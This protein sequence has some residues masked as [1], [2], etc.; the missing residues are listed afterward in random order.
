MA[1]AI[2]SMCQAAILHWWT[3]DQQQA[4]YTNSLLNFANEQ[5]APLEASSQ[6]QKQ[7]SAASASQASNFWDISP[8]FSN[9]LSLEY[10]KSAL[11]ADYT[12]RGQA[13]ACE[14][15]GVTNRKRHSGSSATL[16]Q[17]KRVKSG[18]KKASASQEAELSSKLQKRLAAMLQLITPNE[19]VVSP[20][21]RKLFGGVFCWCVV[22][23][24]R[25]D[26]FCSS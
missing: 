7:A 18:S 26:V 6:P 3:T 25:I 2:R 24:I 12:E 14:A 21:A 13:K 19:K 9:L 8:H 10:P 1:S 23:I 15:Q 11:P 16:Q 20:F 5:L 4:L 17:P 22:F